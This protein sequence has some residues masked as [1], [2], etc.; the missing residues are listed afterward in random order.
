MN[1][2]IFKKFFQ[3]SLIHIST[4]SSAQPSPALHSLPSFL[5]VTLIWKYYPWEFQKI[6]PNSYVCMYHMNIFYFI[7]WIS[8]QHRERDSH[9][10]STQIIIIII[11]ENFM[12]MRKNYFTFYFTH[13]KILYII[14]AKSVTWDLNYNKW[15]NY[16]MRKLVYSLVPIRLLQL[17][18]LLLF[19]FLL[20]YFCYFT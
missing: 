11:M 20:L 1:L 14:L 15:N 3:H 4:I 12:E 9:I 2:C 19:L 17:L 16:E 6:F 13:I 7:L 5:F 8:Y 18:L 10:S